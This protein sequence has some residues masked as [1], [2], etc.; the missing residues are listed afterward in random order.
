MLRGV[1]SLGGRTK[2]GRMNLLPVNLE[3]QYFLG[4]ICQNLKGSQ[5]Q[6]LLKELEHS[7]SL[8]TVTTAEE[9]SLL[10][11]DTIPMIPM[12]TDD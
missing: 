11:N 9:N 5:I 3:Y 7:E 1:W 4:R 10:M 8:N 6:Q 2:I 12:K